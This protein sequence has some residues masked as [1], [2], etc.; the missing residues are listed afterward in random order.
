MLFNEEA[1]EVNLCFSMNG[2]DVMNNIII[3]PMILTS[4]IT[5]IHAKIITYSLVISLVRYINEVSLCFS[6]NSLVTTLIHS[7]T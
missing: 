1:N 7:K 2:N 6:M 4:F 3:L 5:I